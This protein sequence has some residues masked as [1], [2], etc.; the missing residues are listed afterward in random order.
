M[1]LTQDDLDQGFIHYF[2]TGLQGLCDL[3]KFDATDG[4]NALIDRYVCITIGF[5]DMVFPEVIN[6]SVTREKGGKVTFKTDLLSTSDVNG[7]DENLCFSVIR[8]SAWGHVENFYSPGVPVVFFTQLQLASNKIYCIHT[9]EDE[10]KI[11]SFE[12]EV[13]DG[14]NLVFLTFRVTITDVDNKKPI[15]TIG[16]LVA[17]G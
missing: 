5:I 8:S 6:K 14:Y 4:I 15:L 9:G 17:C 13:T 10:V 2:H 11:D 16:D 12:F 1:N 7:P 3:V